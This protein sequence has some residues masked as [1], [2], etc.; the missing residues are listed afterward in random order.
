MTLQEKIPEI[1]NAGKQLA[2][3]D[4][5]FDGVQKTMTD[6]IQEVKQGLTIINQVQT[7]LP[8]IKQL[9]KKLVRLLISV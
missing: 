6:G 3:I 2:M 9:G 8:A 5:D 4:Q 7:Q 1:E